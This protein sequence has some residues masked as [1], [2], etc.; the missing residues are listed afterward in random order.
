[1]TKG[2]VTA[3]PLQIFW[4]IILPLSHP[5]LITV[6]LFSDLSVWDDFLGPLIYLN[7]ESKYTVALGL[8]LFTGL[9]NSQWHLLMA[10]SVMVVTP[11]IV[12]F[13]VAQRYF[14]ESIAL[15]GIKG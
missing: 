12:V 1:M 10:A 15:T 13:F 6:A 11:V 2:A 4:H 8:R 7:D 9:Y 14:V 3:H 5:A